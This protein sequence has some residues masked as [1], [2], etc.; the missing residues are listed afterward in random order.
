MSKNIQPVTVADLPDLLG[1][2]L[3]V[4]LLCDECF[5]QNSAHAGDYWDRPKDSIF[6]H[7]GKPMRLVK[8]ETR[9]IDV[10][11]KKRKAKP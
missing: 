1:S 10:S 4:F 3:P 6:T 9:F 7:C 8:K 2:H 11:F 5:E